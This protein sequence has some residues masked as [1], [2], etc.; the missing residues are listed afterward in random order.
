MESTVESGVLTLLT[1]YG[2]VPESTVPGKRLTEDL[3][4]SLL[5]LMVAFGDA[6]QLIRSG[7]VM[8]SVVLGSLLMEVSSKLQ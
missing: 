8:V 2:L 6:T 5:V 4:K 7:P 3:S 1:K